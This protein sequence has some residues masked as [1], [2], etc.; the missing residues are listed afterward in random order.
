[1]QKVGYDQT[2]LLELAAHGSTKETLARAQ[3]A[4]QKLERLLQ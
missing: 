4:R 2:L 3:K 1:V